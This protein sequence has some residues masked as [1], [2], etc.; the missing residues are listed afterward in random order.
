MEEAVLRK[1]TIFLV[2]VE[3]GIGILSLIPWGK[4]ADT[5]F[6]EVRKTG[7]RSRRR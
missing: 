1:R 2:A 3:I 6:K 4:V 7:S 5:I